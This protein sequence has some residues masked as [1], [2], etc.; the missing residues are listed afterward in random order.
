MWRCIAPTTGKLRGISSSG[1][2]RRTGAKNEPQHCC[3]PPC[4]VGNALAGTRTQVL[5]TPMPCAIWRG[6]YGKVSRLNVGGK[7]GSRHANGSNV[8][9]RQRPRDGD[10]SGHQVATWRL[11]TPISDRFQMSE[12]LQEWVSVS[13][14][15]H[16]SLLRSTG[17]SALVSTSLGVLLPP[18]TTAPGEGA[19]F[20]T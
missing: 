14:R 2:P 12:V 13:E 15:C 10:C 4:R 1:P 11:G 5:A 20:N 9:S 3:R 8:G 16:C 17:T 7:C 18:P 19:V 6:A